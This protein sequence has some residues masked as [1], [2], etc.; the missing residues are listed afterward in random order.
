VSEGISR[1][2]P[3]H[4]N[5]RSEH[6]QNIMSKFVKLYVTTVTDNYKQ[7]ENLNV[8]INFNSIIPALIKVHFATI[9]CFICSN[10]PK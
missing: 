8:L 1:I 4:F 7:N 3:T 10:N 2:T 9:T 5:T 6:Y